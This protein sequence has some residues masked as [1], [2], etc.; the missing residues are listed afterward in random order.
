MLS[1]FAL[2]SYPQNVVESIVVAGE[3]YGPANRTGTFDEA[4]RN[5]DPGVGN[6]IKDRAYKIQNVVK[7]GTF[8]EAARNVDPGV[9]NVIK[10]QAYIIQNAVKVGT[11]DEAARNTDPGIANVIKDQAYIIQ[12]AAKVGTFDEAARNTDPGVAKVQ[13]AT[14]YKILN[15]A[16]VGELEVGNLPTKG[17]L[18][19]E[20]NGDGTATATIAGADDGTEN[21]IEY[22]GYGVEKFTT[23]DAITGNGSKTITDS[24]GLYNAFNSS[25]NA[26]GATLFEAE[27]FTITNTDDAVMITLAEL[28]KDEI[29]AVAVSGDI[30]ITRTYL[31]FIDFKDMGSDI[32]VFVVPRE[33][34]NE[35]ET[36]AQDK[37]RFF[38]D[39]GSFKTVATDAEG[40]VMVKY[41]EDI[42]SRMRHR[43]LGDFKCMGVTLEPA[44]DQI[45]LKEKKQFASVASLEF[46]GVQ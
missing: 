36:R 17:T 19:I 11:F 34:T 18:T 9:G 38:I 30:T 6:V 27:P 13:L 21:I 8:D 5:V 2:L 23:L 41:M 7:V 44:F 3:D 40:D 4:A 1:N 39:V 15:V 28:V 26:N 20:N 14:E 32:Q 16:K 35:M 45:R 24:A 31:G 37:V 29:E 42:Y 33:R 46:M 43:R 12:N 25:A 10:D 22:A